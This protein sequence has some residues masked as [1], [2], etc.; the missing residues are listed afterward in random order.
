MESHWDR[1]PIHLQEFIAEMAEELRAIDAKYDV[2]FGAFFAG[3]RC[4]LVKCSHGRIWMEEGFADDEEYT[5]PP[6]T[7]IRNLCGRC[8]Y[9]M[10]MD[11]VCEVAS[12]ARSD[13]ERRFEKHLRRTG[14]VD[15]FFVDYALY[16]ETGGT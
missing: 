7:S 15:Y 1:L 10:D 16:R 9:D 2:A 8:Y 13:S 11:D 6:L 4:E 12:S 3:Y 5:W 14:R